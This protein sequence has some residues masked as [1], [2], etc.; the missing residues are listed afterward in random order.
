MTDE[1]VESPF[2][3]GTNIQFAWDSTSLGYLKTCPRLYQYIM[4]EGWQAKEESVHL[5]WGILYHEAMQDYDKSVIKGKLKHDDAVFDVVREL[6]FKTVNWPF[7]HNTKTRESLIRAVIWKLDDRENDPAKTYVL[8]DGEP[9]VEQSFK[10]PLDYGPANGYPYVL[11]GHLD[12]IANYQDDLYGNDYKSVYTLWNQTW[13]PDN[14]MTLYT[15]ATNIIL[16]TTVRGMMVDMV[17]FKTLQGHVIPIFER[18]FTQRAPDQ[19]EEWLVDLEYW[20]N[21]A[22]GYAEEGRWPMNDTS[23]G[24]YGG[25]RFRDI[26]SKSPSVRQVFLESN[27]NKVPLEERWNPLKPR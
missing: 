8:Q 4:L 19:L 14:Q 22:R 12:R 11:C 25:C 13:E 9:A 23:C 20:F 15:F 17:S 3:K 21:L 16:H 10:Y 1:P 6:L 2:V 7:D 5:T 27:F 26:C 24:K 18:A